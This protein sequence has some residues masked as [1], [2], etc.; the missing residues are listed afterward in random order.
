MKIIDLN[1]KIWQW[2]LLIFI[3]FIWGASFILMKR[4]LES[5][6]EFQLG[7]LRIFF[8]SI[9]LLPLLF[10]RL[11]KIK[12]KYIKGILI[13]GFIGNLF[14]ALLF[15]IAQTQINS[16]LAGMLNT[17]FPIFTLIIGSLF[18][19]LKAEKNKIL[20][21]V[22]G[23]IGSVGIVLF[24]TSD[25]REG[26]IYYAFFIILA[27]IFY[28]ISI[29]VIKY[30]LPDI[31]GVTITVFS[32]T[33]IGPVAGI[34]LLFSDFSPALATPDFFENLIY[35][36][37]LALGGSAISVTL[38]YLLMDYVD[39]IFA[40]LTTYFISIFAVFWGLFDGENINFLQFLFLGLIFFG[41]FM[42]NKKNKK[43]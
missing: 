7:T 9:F 15:A 42:V 41:I 43:K 36:A 14:P 23:L 33:I 20:G 24:S 16:S 32:F 26:N 12:K 18:F 17:G 39:V 19:G 37:L 13:I 22:L 38:F 10:R 2:I 35:V 5:F 21:V 8:A 6:N 3:S 11:K 29:N 4:G 27:M 28:A 1:K 31:D 34:S 25:F 30:K 40:S